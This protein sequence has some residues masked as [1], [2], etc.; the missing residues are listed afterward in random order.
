M[1]TVVENENDLPRP[2]TSSYAYV[3]SGSEPTVVMH[4]FLPQTF[5][6]ADGKPWRHQ[7]YNVYPTHV[8]P[9]S[10]REGSGDPAKATVDAFYKE[11]K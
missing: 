9:S 11:E 6:R 3:R 7:G 8:T 5:T 10:V 2:A 1:N 4:P